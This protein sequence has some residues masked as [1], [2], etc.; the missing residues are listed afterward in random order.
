MSTATKAFECSGK[1]FQANVSGGA[2]S[3]SKC[4]CFGF[5]I[6]LFEDFRFIIVVNE[7][8]KVRIN[9]KNKRI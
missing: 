9:G 5:V 3:Q 1:L 7:Y 8:T 4:K 2:E 6:L